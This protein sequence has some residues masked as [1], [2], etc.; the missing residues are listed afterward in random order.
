[1]V[2]DLV[3]TAQ[4]VRIFLKIRRLMPIGGIKKRP[5]HS[6]ERGF[7]RTVLAYEKRQR[8]EVGGLLFIEAAKVF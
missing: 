1:M 3:E 5:N 7:A 2:S 4:I 8:C 6:H